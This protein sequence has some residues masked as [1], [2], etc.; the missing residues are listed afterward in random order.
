MS[1][2]V[3]GSNVRVLSYDDEEKF[4]VIGKIGTVYHIHDFETE[5]N[6]SVRFEDKSSEDFSEQELE[7][8]DESV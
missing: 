6:I 7:L 3:V 8:I 1:N 2:I 5:W 4:P